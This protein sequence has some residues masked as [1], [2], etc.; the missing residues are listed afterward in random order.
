MWEGIG[1][2][3]YEA[4]LKGVI[5]G[6]N[7]ETFY[8]GNTSLNGDGN[9][10][11]VVFKLD[12]S[13]YAGGDYFGSSKLEEGNKI[14]RTFDK[15]F[16]IIGSTSGKGPNVSDIYFIK[17]DSLFMNDTVCIHTTE[18]DDFNAYS[19]DLR[20]FPNPA[21]N[22][23]F[24]ELKSFT[25]EPLNIKIY[26]FLG[27]CVCEFPQIHAEL[28]KKINL[29]IPDHLNG[30]YLLEIFLDGKYMREKVIFLD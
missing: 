18:I 1:G 23:I 30:Y 14:I 6:E 10:D 11:I 19:D 4:D 29:K 16:V 25:S 21:K 15:G 22:N 27:Q 5:S 9:I 24:L 13:G 3:N 8:M 2:Y 26:N 7:D 28:N 12:N 17:T 20:L